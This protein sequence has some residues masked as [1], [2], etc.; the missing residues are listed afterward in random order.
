MPNAD[1]PVISRDF[2]GAYAKRAF[3]VIAMF[4]IVG[5]GLA[6]SLRRPENAPPLGLQSRV[7]DSISDQAIVEFFGDRGGVEER[8]R[9]FRG[10][11]VLLPLDLGNLSGYIARKHGS[12]PESRD[13]AIHDFVAIH[14]T[15]DTIVLSSA[16][17]IPGFQRERMDPDLRDLPLTR[18]DVP[19]PRNAAMTLTIVYTWTRLGGELK[20]YRFQAHE[21]C[22]PICDSCVTL[23]RDLGDATY[24]D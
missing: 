20:R 16:E 4:T 6:H 5:Y 19:D 22:A 17:D 10:A 3:I 9:Y 11:R 15:R 23:Q 13:P 1:T 2:S 14:N 21:R 24:L 18:R 8:Y 12:S 7:V